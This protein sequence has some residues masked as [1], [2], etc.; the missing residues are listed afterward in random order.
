M[1]Q[2][3]GT[4]Q[5][6]VKQLQKQPVKLIQRLGIGIVVF[7]SFNAN[8]LINT[9]NYTGD[10]DS[11]QSLVQNC[12][13]DT[14]K[15]R[16]LSDFFWLYGNY[17]LN[18][19]KAI[20]EWAY[21]EIEKSKNLKALSDGYDIRGFILESEKKY[22]SAYVFFLKALDISRKIGYHS[23]AR[24]SYYHLGLI[25]AAQGNIDSALFYM[26][27]V[28]KFDIEESDMASACDALYEK[29]MIFLKA[30]EADS[31]IHNLNSMLALSREIGDKG[32]EMNARLTI[33]SFYNK[34]NNLKN[35][36]ESINEALNLAEETDNQKALI[37]I[38]YLI[39]DVFIQQKKNYDIAMLYYK[40]VYEICKS[41]NKEWEATILN[42]IGA[43]Y[44]QQ[45][46]DSLALIYVN[47][48][49][50]LSRE[51]NYKHQVSESYRNL[52]NIYKHQGKLPD[53][54]NSFKICYNTGCDK[55]QKIVF[56]HAL[57]DIADAYLTLQNRPEAMSFY[58]ESLKLAE[59]F[60]S[61]KELAISN[62]RLGNYY[63]NYD[64]DLSRRYYLSA[65]GQARGSKDLVTTKAIAD[66]LSSFFR[67]SRNYKAAYEY[68]HLARTMEDSLNKIA[69]QASMADLELK[70][71][72][73][74]LKKEN[75][76]KEQ[77]SAVEIKRQKLYRNGALI[78]T[79]LL[80]ILGLVV[81]A[82]YRRKKKANYE[83]TTQKDEIERIS[84]ELHQADEMK[85]R[86]FANVSHEF[87]TPLTLILN[88]AKSLLETTPVEAE[89]KK[90]LEYIYNNA[91]KLN[92]LTNQ[93][94]DLQKLDAGK[95]E[96]KPEEDDIVEFCIGIISSFESL[97]YKKSNTIRIHSNH[98]SA[99]MLFDKDKLGKII[100]NL[101]SNAFKFCYESTAIEVSIEIT[102]NH[103]LLSITDYGIGIPTEEIDKA[104]KQ[105]YQASTNSQIEGTGIGLAYVKELTGFMNG[106]VTIDSTVQKGTK[107]VVTIPL[108]SCRISSNAEYEMR[109]PKV[110]ST[111]SKEYILPDEPKEDQSTVLIVEDNDELR[112]FIAD[113]LKPH[114]NLVMSVDGY[115]GMEAAYK[116]I[117]DLIIS[118]IMMPHMNGFEMCSTLKKDERTS[119][120]PVIL[121]T[122]KDDAPSN[123][124]GYLTG[125]DD[126]I[127]KPFDSE[128]LRLK[129]KNII[130][131][132]VASR[133]QFDLKTILST[134]SFKFGNTDKEFMRKCLA[135]IEKHMDNS[136]FSVELLAV[137]M[138]FSNRN[139]YRK[140]KA[141]TNL[142]PAELV[143]IYRLHYA[144]RL[145]Q[146]TGMKVFEIAMA[147]GYEDVNRFRQA[148]KKL[149]GF[150]PSESVNNVIV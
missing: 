49:L 39:G 133:K 15:F 53:A 8:A 44:L 33:M 98:R 116:V 19:V 139:F 82:S 121:L 137:E 77:L 58:T 20:G 103:F 88:P 66:T 46:N 18:R 54:I 13:T 29:A 34:T 26:N 10:T 71:V 100:S 7:I 114:Y 76:A 70:F 3:L 23:R 45:G 90:Q 97:C 69:Q 1:G 102:D 142:T 87:R 92:D 21:R 59:E 105:Y 94:M 150:P 130:A 43:L 48:G 122:A 41:K 32:K 2:P 85:L 67:N 78:I 109:I 36:L 127:L 73:E 134:G 110:K 40:K 22:D 106:R 86:F 84:T 141:L 120:I 148:F 104:F 117:P 24:W 56:H 136:A 126:Y 144:K 145:L 51:L 57:I 31:A 146:N 101:L 37:K 123:L 119:H 93:I 52:G 149:F 115:S 91:L 47:K 138:S 140:I 12:T 27:T 55:C 63:R 17:D 61:G 35:L 113:M 83:I 96:L 60:A 135:I 38:Y 108:T 131:T 107:V 42:D 128:L 14:C 68:Q 129:I 65:I 72:F 5:T 132:G 64:D 75:E 112:N 11:L 4:F 80:V 50:Q 30:G 81:Y 118:D 79:S 16:I 6:W 74:R 89:H 9:T 143:R 28:Y 95:L 147:V 124:E 25:Q 99:R 111:E 125:A 62:L